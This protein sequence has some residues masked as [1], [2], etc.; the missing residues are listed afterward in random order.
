[1]HIFIDEAGAF[2]KPK[3]NKS[4]I[5][6]VGAL[7]IPENQIDSIFEGFVALK[8]KW[9]I[10]SDE[11]KGS[12]LDEKQI[13]DVIQYI[14]NYDVMFE[15][16]VI[17]MLTQDEQLITE[18]KIEQANF[19][20]KN[21]TKKFNPTLIANLHKTKQDIENLPN[22]LYIQAKLTIE[23]LMIILQ[24][25]TLYYSQRIP[26][27]L[28]NF[29]CSVDAKNQKI[30]T[31]EKLWKSLILPISQTRFLRNPIM[32]FKE[33]DYSHFFN[34]RKIFEIPEYLEEVTDD[35]N[36]DNYFDPKSIFGENIIFE[37]SQNSLG[38][39]LA[40]ILTTAFRRSMNG[41]LQYEGWKEFGKIM[42]QSSGQTVA[43]LDLSNTQ[44]T[45]KYESE[46]LYYDIIQ[47]IQKTRKNMLK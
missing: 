39:Q 38:L 23:L 45:F 28:A 3:E 7:I 12:K 2:I 20:I 6:A 1:M 8:E 16:V 14:S 17:D 5:S 30:T 32:F 47:H 21:I 13:S 33:G 22:Q 34:S 24:K 9:G 35:K 25:S 31:Y 4:N 37:H 26:T 43:L 44:N 27:S 40:D 10:I 19:M 41:N 46:P 15:T 18:H 36:P 11:I 42:V 29:I